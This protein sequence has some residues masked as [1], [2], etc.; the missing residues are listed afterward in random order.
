[1][2]RVALIAL[3]LT[4]LTILVACAEYYDAATYPEARFNPGDQ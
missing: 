4:T 3:W 1:M 2:K